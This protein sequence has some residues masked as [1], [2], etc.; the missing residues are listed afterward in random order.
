MRRSFFAIILGLL[1]LGASN[2]ST[3][4]LTVKSANAKSVELEWTG[5]SSAASLERSATQGYAKVAGGDAG[6]FTDTGIDAFG[7]YKYRINTN[8]KFSNEVMVGPPPVGVSN[9]ASA[10]AGS[11]YE[12][13]GAAIAVALDENG[14]PSIAYEWAD[15]N[16]DGDSTDTEIRFV[17]W[18]RAT[19]KWAPSV[20]VIVTG[21]LQDQAVNPIALAIDRT[22]GTIAILNPKGEELNYLLSND[23]GATWKSL[24][25]SNTVGFAHAVSM[26][27]AAG[28]VH[29]VVNGEDSAVYLTGAITDPASWKSQAV[30]AGAGWKLRNKSNIGLALDA[31]G[32]PALAYYEDQQEGDQHR[33]VFWRPGQSEPAVIYAGGNSD[34]PDIALSFGSGRFGSLTAAQLDAGDTDH[35]VWYSSSAD[36]RSWSKPS[37]LPVD[38]PRSTNAPL[39][40]AIDSK[41]AVIAAYGSNSGS[42]AAACG[43]PTVARSADGVAWK[44]CGLG[45]AAGGDFGPQPST[46]HVVEAGDDRAYVVWQEP[47]ETKYKPGVLVWHGR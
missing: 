25:V 8:G 33:Y 20:R 42:G 1:L 28:L 6:H 44:A 23:H 30:P 10:A 43:A 12:K 31:S 46:I 21:E 27:V 14:D 37:K 13:Y 9:A 29:A 47:A 40:L 38:G 2:L 24:G 45:K 17:R 32:K 3:Q 36:G 41:G 5:G 39:N 4:Q 15:P 22:N 34:T 7:T 11:Q 26:Q 19:Y 35:T 16:A 18:D